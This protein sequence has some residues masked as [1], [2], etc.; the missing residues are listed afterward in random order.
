VTGGV[1]GAYSAVYPHPGPASPSRLP[2]RRAGN[3]LAHQAG[4]IPMGEVSAGGVGEEGERREEWMGGGG[5]GKGMG[6]RGRGRRD[7]HT[8]GWKI[9]RGTRRLRSAPCPS[10]SA[11]TVINTIQR[12][13]VLY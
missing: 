12:C 4:K 13:I 1:R 3:R 11:G 2:P 5:G 8:L 9:C 10:A 6:G 7:P